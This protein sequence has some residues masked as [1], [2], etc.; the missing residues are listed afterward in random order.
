VP[1]VQN[2]E[3]VQA[4]FKVLN[5]G[6]LASLRGVAVP[7]VAVAGS[8]PGVQG[9]TAYLSA[10]RSTFS[11]PEFKV[12]DSIADGEKVAV[13]FSAKATHAGRYLGIPATG[14]KLK[15]WGVMIFGFENGSIS[16]FWSVIDA[17]GVLEQLRSDR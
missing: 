11:E 12:V 10:L 9:L 5:G 14:R 3:T 6:D 8:Q 4:F 1:R 17:Q 13:R 2:L 7:G 16:E 15:L